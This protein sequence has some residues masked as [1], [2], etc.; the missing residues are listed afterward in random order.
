M[1]SV[2][3]ITLPIYLVMAVGYVATR[4]GL[5]ARADMR[6]F[7]KYVINLALPALLFNALSSRSVGEVLE[8][9]FVLAYTAGGL[10]AMGA[11]I[12]W[13]RR[14]GK[15]LS[16][17]ATAGM[18]MSCPNSGFIGFP[19]VMQLFGAS[20]AGVG[21]ALAMV[22]ENLLLLPL[23]LAIADSDLG[24]APPG[25]TRGQRLR[26]ALWQ[27]LRGIARNPMIH[28]IAFGFL[29]SLLGWRLPEPLA[30]AVNLFAVSTAAISLMVIGGSLV[31]IPARG[32]ARD[33]SAVAIGKLLLHPLAVLALV[34]LLPPMQ[35]ELQVAVV[36]MAAVPMLGI[37]PILAQKHGHDG[38]A[39]AA[40]LGTTV[41]SFF[42]LTAVLW[43]LQ[44]LPV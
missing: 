32:M 26:A 10:V 30:R 22:V 31:G 3:A 19:L 16:A 39:A 29:F 36:V 43:L 14:A 2:L 33:V 13:A 23:A 21:L 15:S 24:D 38:M 11:G 37:Y 12:L 28:G 4:A 1:G 34:W 9:V 5:F 20:T 40:Q 6:V 42:T 44:Q 27:S 17:A 41:A 35:R 25:S 8:P 7:G 18:G